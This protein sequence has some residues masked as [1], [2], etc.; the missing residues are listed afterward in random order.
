[1]FLERLHRNLDVLL[2]GMQGAP[3]LASKAAPGVVVLLTESCRSC[4]FVLMVYTLII[5]SR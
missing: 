3:P 4:K 1:M 5:L 2:L